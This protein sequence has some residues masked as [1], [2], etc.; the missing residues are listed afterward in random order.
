MAPIAWT[1]VLETGVEALDADHR[2]LIDQCNNLTA[3]M[4]EAGSWGAAVESA[5]RLTEDCTR[6]FRAE[7]ELLERTEFPRREQHREKHREIEQRFNEMIALL[8]GTDELRPEH[9]QTLRAVRDTLV[10]ILFRHDLDYKSHLQQVA[11]R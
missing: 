11:G 2:A 3:L 9:R 7:E 1:D 5:R 4:E 10:D 8:S 6:H